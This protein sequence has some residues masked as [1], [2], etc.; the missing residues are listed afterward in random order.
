MFN[1]YSTSEPFPRISG[2]VDKARE[3]L[4]NSMPRGGYVGYGVPGDGD[5]E[6]NSFSN[7]LPGR[8]DRFENELPREQQR[9]L[10]RIREEN[11]RRAEEL[12]REFERNR[13]ETRDRIRDQY[14]HNNDFHSRFHGDYRYGFRDDNY[15]YRNDTLVLPPDIYYYQPSRRY[16]R[17]GF[18]EAW[19]QIYVHPRGSSGYRPP[20][21]NPGFPDRPPYGDREKDG[22]LRV[23]SS[24]TR[25]DVYIENVYYGRTPV[26]VEL[27]EGRYE[28]EVYKPGYEVWTDVLSVTKDKTTSTN[29]RLKARR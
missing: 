25:A 11:Q 10:D 29:M 18:G 17:P 9:Q 27:P 16:I 6:R 20:I 23:T 28:V 2:G 14:N 7:E 12:R 5:D 8:N 4:L 19:T 13:E 1:G 26:E 3:E 15:R 24:P 22:T 21:Y